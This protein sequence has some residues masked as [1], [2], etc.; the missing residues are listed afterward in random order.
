MISRAT[1]ECDILVVWLNAVSGGCI[2]VRGDHSA[3]TTRNMFKPSTMELLT[4]LQ[5]LGSKYLVA[6]PPA[7]LTLLARHLGVEHPL[8]VVWGGRHNFH[9]H[10]HH[11]FRCHTHL[12]STPSPGWARPSARPRSL[13]GRG[14]CAG[15]KVDGVFAVVTGEILAQAISI[16]T[17]PQFTFLVNIFETLYSLSSY[18]GRFS[19]QQ[20]CDWL[21]CWF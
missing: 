9:H 4:Q 1:H 6:H 5:G 19:M 11:H 21:S 2:A 15:L 13:R 8:V 16:T 14:R 12:W 10:C 18:Y 17:S 3:L 7:V 20:A